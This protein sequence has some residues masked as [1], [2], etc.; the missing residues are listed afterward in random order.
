MKLSAAIE[1]ALTDRMYSLDGLMYGQSAYMCNV[2]KCAGHHDHVCSVQN[3]VHRI[4]PNP[5]KEQAL[6][7]ALYDTGY[8]TVSMSRADTFAYTSELYVWWVFDLKRKGL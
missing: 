5:V 4:N 8:I 3:M 2:L 7:S 1:S 6:V